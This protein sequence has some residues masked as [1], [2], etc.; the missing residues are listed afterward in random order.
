ML[1]LSSDGWIQVAADSIQRL[2]LVPPA[3]YN[4][5]LI[6]SCGWLWP[7]AY[8]SFGSSIRVT[9]YFI[10]QL[11]TSCSW[12][13]PGAD[14]ISGRT[15]LTAD[16]YCDISIKFTDLFCKMHDFYGFFSALWFQLPQLSSNLANTNPVKQESTTRET[17]WKLQ[18]MKFYLQN[19]IQLTIDISSTCYLQHMSFCLQLT[20]MSNIYICHTFFSR[21]WE[22]EILRVKYKNIF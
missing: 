21:Y 5:R 10:L 18:P 13:Q 6:L 1:V 12:F 7:A 8:S 3:G 4:F 15:R 2:A 20:F 9:A 16:L 17:S 11:T 19:N 14:L 22:F